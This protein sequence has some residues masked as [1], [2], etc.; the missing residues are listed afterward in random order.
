MRNRRKERKKIKL[1]SSTRA[2]Y[3]IIALVLFAVSSS[4]I[5]QEIVN[6][7]EEKLKKEVY[8]YTNYYQANYEMKIKENRFIE[9]ET[10]P[11]GQTYVTELLDSM[12]LN[13]LY[14]YEASKDANVEYTYDITA[15]IGAS[16]TDN[17]KE[18]KVWNKKYTLLEQ[19]QEESQGDIQIKELVNID[20]PKYNKEV[21]D[22]K[23]TTGMALDAYLNVQL[24]VT[25]IANI[26]DR[27]VENTYS[28]DFKLTLGNKITI[29]DAKGNDTKIGHV[30]EEN[31]VKTSKNVWKIVINL[32][33]VSASIYAVYYVL[34]KTKTLHSI[35]N[36]YKVELNRILKSCQDKIIMVTK[37]IEV[38]NTDLIDVKDFGE[39]I[40]LSEELYKPI[41][42]WNADDEKEA[43]FCV[44]S[45]AVTYKFILKKY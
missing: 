40:K 5:F 26:E 37:K 23:Q 18:Y 20:L 7:D 22:F 13:I 11:M 14:K 10:L 45:N 15:T 2:I 32:V 16:Y 9:E 36:E 34:T 27:K 6:K 21:N 25:T 4:N 33:I 29:I 28:S 38:E 17:G 30:E 1:R 41:L 44:I 35:K 3:I 43:W 12:D 39:L 42:C 24:N 19:K 31:A 8:T